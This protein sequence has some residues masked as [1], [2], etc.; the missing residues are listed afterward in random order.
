LRKT[1]SGVAT[2]I[3]IYIALKYANYHFKSYHLYLLKG[4][5]STALM[6]YVNENTQQQ[7]K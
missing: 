2:Y 6:D 1:F 5:N 3:C 7:L 4:E